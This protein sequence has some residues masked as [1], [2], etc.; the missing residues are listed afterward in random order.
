MANQRTSG[1]TGGYKEIPFRIWPWHFMLQFPNQLLKKDQSRR[2]WKISNGWMASG[3]ACR[4][5]LYSNFSSFGTL[6]RRCT[7]ILRCLIITIWTPSSIGVYS[8]KS[9]YDRFFMGSVQFEPAERIL[10]SWAAPRCKF[11]LWLA[12]LNCCWTMDRLARKGLDH[13]SYCLFCDQEEETIQHILVG[14]IFSKKVWFRVLALAR[15]QR[16][17]VLPPPTHMHE[18]RHHLRL[19]SPHTTSIISSGHCRPL[20]PLALITTC[21]STAVR[22]RT[23]PPQPPL[24]SLPRCMHC[25]PPQAP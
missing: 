11:F 22:T 5:K 12:S 8:S 25:P 2:L 20:P 7:S 21:R 19:R 1:L 10:N 16:C 13:P 6:F 23:L 24:W 17:S 14:C 9:A 3:P 18:Y 4:P 15:L